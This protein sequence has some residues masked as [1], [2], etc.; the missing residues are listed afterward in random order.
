M[1]CSSFICIFI[2]N[3]YSCFHLYN[4]Y[5][6]PQSVQSAASP[7][8]S[9]L[10]MKSDQSMGQPI[11]FR[12]RALDGGFRPQSVQSAASPARSYLSMK[13]DQSMGQPIN[14]RDF[15]LFEDHRRAKQR[16]MSASTKSENITDHPC[17]FN[18]RPYHW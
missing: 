18:G 17:T 14:F 3:D 5:Y 13:S 6:S 12:D 1:V 9:Y 10:S 4:L 8:R 11:N 15:F 2:Y 16:K 7:A